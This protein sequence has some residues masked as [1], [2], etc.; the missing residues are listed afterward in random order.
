MKQPNHGY[1]VSILVSVLA[2][3][4]GCPRQATSA[5]AET[6]NVAMIHAYV[7]A[8]NKGDK[9]YLDKYLGPGYVYHSPAGDLDEQGFR[10]LHEKLLSAFPGLTFQIDD[11]IAAGDKVVTR[12]TFRGVQKGE[13]QGI[14]PTNKAVTMTGIV[15]T[16]FEN[17]KAVE[18]W[19]EA[20]LLGLMRQLGALPAPAK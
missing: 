3:F 8:V 11:V 18:E 10:A 16:R 6:Q 20:N 1:L 12:W 19:E 15:I 9:S 13:F 14:A 17:G 4:A 5:T 7:D 2:V